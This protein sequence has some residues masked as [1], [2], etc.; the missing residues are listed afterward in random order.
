MPLTVLKKEIINKKPKPNQHFIYL[1]LPSRWAIGK[2]NCPQIPPEA[3]ADGK[4]CPDR[5]EYFYMLNSRLGEV[6]EACL[7]LGYFYGLIIE[8]CFMVWVR[9]VLPVSFMDQS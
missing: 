7:L 6:G 8:P 1:P 2:T 9:S 3:I 5:T 4:C